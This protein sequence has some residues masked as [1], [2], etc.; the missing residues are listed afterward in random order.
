MSANPNEYS[1]VA[2]DP[3]GITGWA[4]F[5]VHKKAFAKPQNKILSNLVEYDWGEFDGIENDQ[6]EQ[7]L[8]LIYETRFRP[9]PFVRDCDVVTEDFVLLQSIGGKELLSPVRINAALDYALYRNIN[10]T[11]LKLT[12]QSRSV[13]TGITRERLAL[14][15]FPKVRGKDAFA[16]VQHAITWLRR[17]KQAHNHTPQFRLKI[18]EDLR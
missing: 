17:L 1:V 2:F 8:Q 11:A 16:A 4:V 13:R 5:T 9:M 10:G 18:N 3:G 7:A 12:Y 14:W 15:G 6:I